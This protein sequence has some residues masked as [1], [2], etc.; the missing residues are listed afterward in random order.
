[1]DDSQLVYYRKFYKGGLPNVGDEL[2]FDGH[3]VT[4]ESFESSETVTPTNQQ[5]PQQLQRQ[6]PQ[7]TPFP[8]QQ[9]QMA[10]PIIQHTSSSTEPSIPSSRSPISSRSN[11]FKPP[12]MIPKKRMIKVD[13]EEEEAEKEELEAMKLCKVLDQSLQ[14]IQPSPSAE[15]HDQPSVS[16][17]PSSTIPTIALQK[18]VRVGLSKRTASTLHQS[19]HNN[20]MTSLGSVSS[21]HT[22]PT[23]AVASSDLNMPSTTNI[24]S[25]SS[26][27]SPTP[28]FPVNMNTIPSK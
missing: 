24:S 3:I 27:P 18:R 26:I 16:N 10:A 2:E 15:V 8:P 5:L 23:P 14:N 6:S 9:Q 4:V 12:S 7:P 20:R 22:M 19:T 25:N 28:S 13:P 11:R 17:I 1:V 21:S